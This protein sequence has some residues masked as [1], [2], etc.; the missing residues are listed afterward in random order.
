MVQAL[1][2]TVRDKEMM[3][4]KASTFVM[5]FVM[6]LNVCVFIGLVCIG[7]AANVLQR[8]EETQ[9][10][11]SYNVLCAIPQFGPLAYARPGW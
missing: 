3:I 10:I 6:M 2:G 1:R 7:Y 5:S 8:A 11:S 9:M 4:R